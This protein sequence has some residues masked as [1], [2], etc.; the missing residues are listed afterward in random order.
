MLQSRMEPDTT[1]SVEFNLINVGIAN[2]GE[3]RYGAVCGFYFCGLVSL[4]G[5]EDQ[6]CQLF[7]L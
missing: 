4:K 2:E 7:R 1:T 6:A 5:E 3:T